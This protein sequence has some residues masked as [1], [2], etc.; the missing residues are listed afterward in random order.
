MDKVLGMIGL[1]VRAGK[2]ISGEENIINAVRSG[3]AHMVLLASDASGNTKKMYSDKCRY[4][5]VRIF[6]YGTK[7]VLNHAALACCDKN[8]SDAIEKLLIGG[9]K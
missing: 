6:E 1:A 9:G 3:K 8:F 5:T 7:E 2:M 4:Y